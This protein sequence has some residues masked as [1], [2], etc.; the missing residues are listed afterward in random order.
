MA[1]EDLYKYRKLGNKIGMPVYVRLL[2]LPQFHIN[3]LSSNF[4]LRSRTGLTLL[5][6]LGPI[7]STSVHWVVFMLRTVFR[8]K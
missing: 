7:L 8:T 1:L 3:W 2:V 5:R 6:M 4:P